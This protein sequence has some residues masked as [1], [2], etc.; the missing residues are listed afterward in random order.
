MYLCT[1]NPSKPL[2]SR[3][4]K[5]C[6]CPPLLNC[7]ALSFL[8]LLSAQPIEAKERRGGGGGVG[9]S[10]GDKTKRRNPPWP[11]FLLLSRRASLFLGGALRR[12]VRKEETRIAMRQTYSV[13]TSHT[14]SVAYESGV[15]STRVDSRRFFFRLDSTRFVN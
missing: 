2:Q 13:A 15:D 6:L 10:S 9:Q 11:L 4:L 7:C 8:L 12:S 5:L 3:K 14:D 1:N